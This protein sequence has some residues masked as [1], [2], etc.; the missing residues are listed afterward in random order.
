MEKV[1]ESENIIALERLKKRAIEVKSDPPLKEEP[2]KVFNKKNVIFWSNTLKELQMLDKQ[3]IFKTYSIIE[4]AKRFLENDCI[5]YVK[6]DKDLNTGGY[7]ICKPIKGY[8]K[9]TYKIRNVDGQFEC[10]CQ[11]YQRVAKRIPKLVCS[12]ILALKLQLKIW[13]SERRWLAEEK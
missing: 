5:D 10:D 8:N 3:G 6:K 9:T 4:K 11:F 2:P 1:E 12:H 7:Y 13:N